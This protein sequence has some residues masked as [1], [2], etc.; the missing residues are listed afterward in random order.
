YA[1]CF[2]EAAPFLNINHVT[3]PAAPNRMFA[4]SVRNEGDKENM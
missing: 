4:E 1:S 3:C 2:R